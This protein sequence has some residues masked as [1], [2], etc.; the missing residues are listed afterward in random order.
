MKRPQKA[1]PW[2]EARRMTYRKS[3]H[4]CG[5][6]ASRRIKQ[7][8]FKK[9]Y[10]RNHNTCFFTCSPRPPTLSQRHM[11]L[12]ERAY[13][14]PDQGSRFGRSH[15]F[16]YS[17]LQQ[18]VYYRA[19][20]DVHVGKHLVWETSRQEMSGNHSVWRHVMYDVIMFCSLLVLFNSTVVW[21][22]LDSTI[23]PPRKVGHKKRKE[24]YV[25]PLSGVV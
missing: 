18:L 7:K 19:S 3:V 21:Y 16:G 20:R 4:F 6:G 1:H 22:I 15:Y 24:V 5:L 25:K 13:P 11:D 8:K 17:L 23:K 12:L 14:R 9:V 10:L 2:A